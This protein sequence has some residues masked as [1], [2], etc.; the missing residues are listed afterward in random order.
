MSKFDKVVD[1]AKDVALKV[2]DEVD[3]DTVEDNISV[4]IDTIEYVN[5][6]NTSSKADNI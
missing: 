4:V 3:L 6:T 1:K 5:K 2:K